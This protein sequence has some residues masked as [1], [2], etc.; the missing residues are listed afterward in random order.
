MGIAFYHSSVKEASIMRKL[1][2]CL[3]EEEEFK[4]ITK[5]MLVP[6]L[7]IKAVYRRTTYPEVIIILGSVFV[8]LL[9]IGCAVE[10]WQRKLVN[11]KVLSKYVASEDAFVI[12]RSAGRKIGLYHLSLI[13]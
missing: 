13:S 9:I 11:K 3:A 7:N 8:L 5:D 1:I 12:Q 6:H 10:I 4:D 2:D